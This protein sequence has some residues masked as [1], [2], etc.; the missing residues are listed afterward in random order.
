[1]TRYILTLLL[2]TGASGVLAMEEK[3]A[4]SSFDKLLSAI[5]KNKV[6]EAE[7]LLD[8]DPSLSRQT[9]KFGGTL[10]ISAASRGNYAI[11]KMLI[12]KGAAVDR[13]FTHGEHK[14]MTALYFAAAAGHIDVVKLLIEA[15]AAV[16]TQ[17]SGG[18][19]ALNNAAQNGHTDTVQT[20]IGAGAD[21][22][23]QDVTGNTA[24][25][26]AAQSGHTDIV[27]SLIEAGADMNKPL[28]KPKG[29]TPL[30]VAA[31]QSHK[32]IV[33][34]LLGN[35]QEVLDLRDVSAAHTMAQIARAKE[36]EK[37]LLD[38][39]HKRLLLGKVEVEKPSK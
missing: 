1:M 10:L 12:N 22:T 39:F 36:I 20:L 14:G 34:V 13:Q 6:E 5:E 18:N 16:D 26:R 38:E 4:V 28:I 29:M 15:G 11:A 9:G 33:L 7:K 8:T 25:F 17:E 24:L 35:G 32:E 23:I 2:A 27:Q 30:M 21:V 31:N 19:T 37:I 3:V